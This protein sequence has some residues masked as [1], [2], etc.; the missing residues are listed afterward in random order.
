MTNSGA[1]PSNADTASVWSYHDG[2]LHSPES[3]RSSRHYL[4]WEN[5]PIPFKLYKD[6]TPVPLPTNFA[7]S[8]LSAL[9]S[10]SAPPAGSGLPRHLDLRRLAKLLFFSAGI[11]KKIGRHGHEMLFRA[12]A[13]TG[14]LYHIELY[15]V[16][17][18]IEGLDAGVFHFSVHDFALRRLHEGDYRGTLADATGGEAAVTVAPATIVFTSTFWRN[19]WKYQ[20]RAYRHSFWDSG[21]MLANALA[22]A[23]ADSLPVKIVLGFADDSVNRLLDVDPNKEAAVA[24]L[25]VGTGGAPPPQAPAVTPLNYAAE[26]VSKTEVSYPAIRKMHAASSLRQAAEV[27][28]WRGEASSPPAPPSVGPVVPLP[29]TSSPPDAP[30]IEQVILRRGSSRSFARE[31]ITFPQLANA[32]RAVSGGIPADFLGGPASTLND[33]YLLVHAVTGLP[34]G[35]YYF[36]RDEAALE[37]LMEGDFRDTGGFLGLG[38]E[39][40][41]DAAVDVFFLTDLHWVMERFGNRGYRAAQMEAAIMG[42]KLYLAAYAQG[43]GASGLTFFDDEVTDFFSPHAAGKS[44][45]FLTALGVPSKRTA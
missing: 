8:S 18:G 36:R 17:G 30:G 33:L 26:P 43:F 5:Q 31:P 35:A 22:V 14:A 11:T 16:C 37:P 29:A 34:S 3:I 13:C 32:L 7:P 42:G 24:L 2:T 10:L 28:A 45:M 12:A 23:A 39:L 1:R 21:T 19:A 15:V 27:A 40:P 9:E 44:V 4:D 41:A 6:L 20:A 38:Q 25:P